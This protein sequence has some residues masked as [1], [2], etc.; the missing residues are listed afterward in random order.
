MRR[1]LIES[2]LEAAINITIAN[3]LTAAGNVTVD[4]DLTS[5][6]DEVAKNM[7][8]EDLYALLRITRPC[9]GRSG[10]SAAFCTTG[11]TSWY[12]MSISMGTALTMAMFSLWELMLELCVRRLCVW[13][14]RLGKVDI[15]LA[16][17]G[18]HLL[19]L[20]LLVGTNSLWAGLLLV[21]I[22]FL[23]ICGGFL[24]LAQLEMV[25]VL[26]EVIWQVCRTRPQVARKFWI[27]KR[28]TEDLGVG[29]IVAE[30]TITLSNIKTYEA[31]VYIAGL[32]GASRP[33]LATEDA[34]PEIRDQDDRECPICTECYKKG[35]LLDILP[36]KLGHRYHATCI[37]QAFKNKLECPYCTQKFVTVGRLEPR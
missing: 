1:G 9:F 12:F 2:L 16:R 34:R 15:W 7:T 31:G 23:V 22:M 33:D 27:C 29:D 28:D 10:L 36:C 21:P 26:T 17:I 20:G 30:S 37:D 19:P 25:A 6:N 5:F 24:E 13:L 3:N 32:S 11:E 35:Q 8:A 18:A 4:A 14:G